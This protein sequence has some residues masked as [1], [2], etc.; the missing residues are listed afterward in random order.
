LETAGLEYINVFD[1][2]PVG[3]L[4]P[5]LMQFARLVVLGGMDAFL[6]EAVFRSEVGLLI[7]ELIDGLC[8][9]SVVLDDYTWTQILFEYTFCPVF[10]CNF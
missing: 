8:K 9:L 3:N 1:V 2:L 4:D 10:F 6:L 7:A 5:E